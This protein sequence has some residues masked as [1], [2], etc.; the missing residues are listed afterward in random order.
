[1]RTLIL[2]LTGALAL[3]AAADVGAAPRPDPYE[4]C[5]TTFAAAPND[6]DSAFCFHQV[7]LDHGLWR[8]GERVFEELIR[9]HPGNFWLTQ[10]IET[11]RHR[12]S[13]QSRPVEYL[14]RPRGD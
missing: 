9:E 14:P 10:G 7:T 3:A 13:H 5:R 6:Y 2:G 11:Q 8:D 4:G 1:M 12:T